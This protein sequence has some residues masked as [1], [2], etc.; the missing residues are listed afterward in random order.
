[1]NVS[2][3]ISMDVPMDIHDDRCDEERTDT[4]AADNTAYNIYQLMYFLRL[5]TQSVA[6]L[7][8]T[9]VSKEVVRKSK[10]KSSHKYEVIPTYLALTVHKSLV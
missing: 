7:Q 10:N 8:R 6:K 9:N 1:M 5:L 3:D 4:Q 2:M